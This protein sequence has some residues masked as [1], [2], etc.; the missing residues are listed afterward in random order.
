MKSAILGGAYQA[1][2]STLANDRCINLYPEL[3]SS[4]NAKTGGALLAVP[5]LVEKLDLV[6]TVGVQGMISCSNGLLYAVCNSNLYEITTAWVATNKGS[7]GTAGRVT[8]AENGTQLIINSGYIYTFAT[9]TLAAITDAD[10]PVG[11]V[12]EMDGYF[13]ANVPGTGRFQASNLDDGTAWDSLDFATAT[14]GPDDVIGHIVDHREWWIFGSDSVEVWYNSGDTDFPFQR[15]QGAFI[16]VGCAAAG[17]IAKLDNSVFWLGQDLRGHGMV[18]RS[19]GYQPQRIS[20]HAIE[21]AI[22]DYSTIS[23]AQAFTYQQEGHSFYVLIFPAEGKTWV[24]DAA[25]ASWH[26]RSGFSAGQFT[27]W[28]ANCY[29]FFNGAHLVGDY[30]S[31]KIYEM[32]ADTHTN[33]AEVKKWLRSWRAPSGEGRRIRF[34]SLQIDCDVGVGLTSGQ[35]SDPQM[36]LRW[37]DDGGKTWSDEHWVSMGRIGEYSTRAIWRRLGMGRDR[38]FEISGPDPVKTNIVAAYLVAG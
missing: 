4:P 17:S 11:T 25:T 30:E 7:I 3:A 29:A 27:R 20:T 26:E 36:M 14:G 21:Y 37:S 19:A 10:F 2:S 15:I 31:G 5:G 8:M 12:R 38:V 24:F 9:S 33:G 32:D 28:R 22:S 1:R 34:K 16:E 35:G 13:L 18:Y 23:D 6:A